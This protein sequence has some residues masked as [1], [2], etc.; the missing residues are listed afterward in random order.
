MERSWPPTQPAASRH[1]ARR[2]GLHSVAWRLQDIWADLNARYFHGAL[3]PIEIQ[4]S[5]RLTASAGMFVSRTGPRA[6]EQGARRRLIRLS[7]PL[8]HAPAL[9]PADAERE[10]VA[11][12][13][14]EMI[15]Q[16]QFDVLKRRPDHGAAFQRKMAVMN[17][18][19]LAVT[20]RHELERAVRAFIRHVWR[21]ERCGCLYE[22]QRR[23]ISPIRHR[24][25]RCRGALN[26][27]VP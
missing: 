10:L 17:R 16:W 20:V 13:A 5:R 3:P 18:D 27:V 23:S 9:A 6:R 22:R 7:V 4:W 8:L 19:G 24:C 21:C 2:A 11:T 25:G 26:E 14:H 12:L 15:H 1:E